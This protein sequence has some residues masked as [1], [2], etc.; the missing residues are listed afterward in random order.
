[1]LD[2]SASM[3]GYKLEQAREGVL[4]FAKDAIRKEYLTG[5]IKFN[6]LA[7]HICEPTKDISYLERH[8]KGYN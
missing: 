6:S 5:L 3:T 2:C 1:M 8:P 4:D 7:M